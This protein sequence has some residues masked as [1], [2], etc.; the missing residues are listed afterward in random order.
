MLCRCP[1]RYAYSSAVRNLSGMCECVLE[2]LG[3]LEQMKTSGVRA[4]ICITVHG[5]PSECNCLIW[6]L[7]RHVVVV[8]T[9]INSKLHFNNWSF[10]VRARAAV[11]EVHAAARAR[12]RGQ[13][14]ALAE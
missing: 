11:R 6:A 10:R 12:R 7:S 1:R 4:V 2:L 9:R 14:V 8:T 5:V 13:P 3:S